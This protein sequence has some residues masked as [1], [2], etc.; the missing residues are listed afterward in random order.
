MGVALALGADF[1]Q[2]WG[3]ITAE[4]RY[5]LGL[6]N[7]DRDGSNDIKQ[8]SFLVLGGVIF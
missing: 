1:Y 3:A 6:R 5:N 2:S 4:V 8:G 7:L